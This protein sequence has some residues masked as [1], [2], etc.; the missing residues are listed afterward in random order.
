MRD[1]LNFFDNDFSAL[2]RPSP[3]TSRRVL[4]RPHGSVA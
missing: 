4:V 2:P 3:L 1:D